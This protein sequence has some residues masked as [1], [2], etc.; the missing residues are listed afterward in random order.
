MLGLG[1]NHA[2]EPTTA[3]DAAETSEAL[4]VLELAVDRFRTTRAK[5]YRLLQSL[6]AVR[7]RFLSQGQR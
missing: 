4:A 3:D 6:W 1:L 2:T 5:D 7:S